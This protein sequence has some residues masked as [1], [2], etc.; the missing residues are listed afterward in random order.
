MLTQGDF[1]PKQPEEPYPLLLVRPDGIEAYYAARAGMESWGSEFGYE[2]IGGDWKLDYRQPD[3]QLAE[4]VRRAVDNGPNQPGPADRR[5]AAGLWQAEA[6]RVSR[7]ADARRRDPGGRLAR[8][9]GPGLPA[10]PAQRGVR[11]P[12]RRTE[13]GPE[14][15]PEPATAR[16]QDMPG[17]RE[18]STASSPRRARTPGSEAGPPTA[19][20][21][22][23]ANGANEDANANT[24][25]NEPG[26]WSA[27]GGTGPE[28]AAGAAGT[29]GP[30]AQ[31]DMMAGRPPMEQQPGAA[32]GGTPSRPGEWHPQEKSD[33]VKRPMNNGRVAIESMAKTRG[34]NW[35]LPDAAAGSVGITRP[36]R[37]WCEADRVLLL[38]EDGR[39]RGKPILLGPR[40]EDSIDDLVSAV[41]NH[42]ESWGIAGKGMYWQ[43]ILKVQVAPDAQQRYEELDGLLRDSGMTVERKD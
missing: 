11:Q 6:A 19:G 8:R 3:P 14:G 30:V 23:H 21:N 27:A 32:P 26:S 7:R 20:G 1:D 5:R 2:L 28:A 4:V 12:G 24:A 10:Q 17:R 38:A 13:E 43:P 33:G 29:A 18:A 9:H 25:G 37:V 31:T 36:I 34:E 35:G 22:S 15:R 41:W 40:T 42:M 39:P 16:S